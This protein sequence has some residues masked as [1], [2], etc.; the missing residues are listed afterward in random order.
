[1]SL[2]LDSNIVIEM[3]NGTRPDYCTRFGIARRSQP[4]LIS[5]IVAFEL[6]FGVANSKRFAENAR[7]LRLFLDSIQ[8]RFHSLLTMLKLPVNFGRL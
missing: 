4:V 6:W 3:M 2:H 8:R 5:T 7:G 1:M